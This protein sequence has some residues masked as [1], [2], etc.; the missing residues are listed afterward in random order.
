MILI[1]MKMIKDEKHVTYYPTTSSIEKIC[2]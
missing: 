2:I 1:W